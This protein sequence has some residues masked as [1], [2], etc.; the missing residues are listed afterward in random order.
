MNNQRQTRVF[1]DNDC[2]TT[3]LHLR[4][5]SGEDVLTLCKQ[6]GWKVPP[7]C[8]DTG[9]AVY[10]RCEAVVSGNKYNM[11]DIMVATIARR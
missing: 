10:R 2:R 7:E 6:M 8:S 3:C 1:S 11:T 9:S 4:R 5:D